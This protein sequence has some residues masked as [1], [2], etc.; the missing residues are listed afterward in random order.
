MAKIFT[1]LNIGDTVAT[2]GTRVFKKL[3]TEESATVLAAG[4]YDYYDNL[5]ASWNTLVNTYGIDCERDYSSSYSDDNYYRNDKANPCYVLKNKSALS[6][7]RKLIIDSS[8]TRIGSRAFCECRSLE[9]VVIPYGVASI[10]NSTFYGCSNI[11]NIVIPKS[12][13]SIGSQAFCYCSFTDIVIPNSVTSIGVSAFRWCRSLESA[14][15]PYGVASISDQLFLACTNL[16]TVVIPDSVTSIGNNAFNECDSLADVYYTGTAEQWA[17]ITVSYSNDN[18][19]NATIH[20]NYK[21]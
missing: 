6:N 17:A 2:S 1:K 20:Y 7:G 4:L 18:L 19:K 15:I 9:S 13:T 12:V 16:K 21:G 11:T 14:V 8:V 5:L 3:S 10:G